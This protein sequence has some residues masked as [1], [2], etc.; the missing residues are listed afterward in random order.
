MGSM[1][2]AGVVEQLFLTISP[3][4]IGGGEERPPFTDGSDL[5]EGDSETELL[6]VRRS[7]D[8]LFLRYRFS[9]SS[10]S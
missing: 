10:A 7:D 6:S 5:L 9:R 1:L 8:Y 4:L 2:E 3:T